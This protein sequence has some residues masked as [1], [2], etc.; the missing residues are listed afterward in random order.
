M[1][2][3]E[4]ASAGLS[5]NDMNTMSCC[6]K[7]G[8]LYPSTSGDFRRWDELIPEARALADHVAALLEN[9]DAESLEAAEEL[10]RAL[11]IIS[12]KAEGAPRKRDLI[13]VASL[14][15]TFKQYTTSNM[16]LEDDLRTKNHGCSTF[17]LVSRN[18]VCWEFCT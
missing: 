1:A 7:H 8:P 16:F 6:V 12:I 13:Q 10:A 2:R 11:M 15:T 3:D 17:I 18:V 9:K 5:G 14:I 4:T